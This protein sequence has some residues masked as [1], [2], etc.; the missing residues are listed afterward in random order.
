MTFT[1]LLALAGSAG[2]GVRVCADSR[3]VAKGDI[4]V[5][6]PGSQV[7]GHN[8]ISQ[9]LARGAGYIVCEREIDCGRAERVIVQNS[10]RAIGLLGHFK[11]EGFSVGCLDAGFR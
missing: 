1:Q 8:F 3:G 10:A 5:A 6:V 11:T 4:F 2:S 9:A 7:D